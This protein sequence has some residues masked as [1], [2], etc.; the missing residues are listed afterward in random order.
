MKPGKYRSIPKFRL[1][2]LQAWMV[3]GTSGFYIKGSL[4]RFLRGENASPMTHQDL[5]DVIEK[6]EN[7]LGIPADEGIVYILELGHTFLTIKPPPLYLAEWKVLRR[8][9]RDEF[10]SGTSVI[11]RNKTWSMSGYDK[12]LELKEKKIANPYSTKYALRLELRLKKSLAVRFGRKIGLRT[13][14]DKSVWMKCIDLF[15]DTYF[16]IKKAPRI[17]GLGTVG[18]TPRELQRNLAIV[19]ERAVSLDALLAQI[20]AEGCNGSITNQNVRRMKAALLAQENKSGKIILAD[21]L[22]PEIDQMVSNLGSIL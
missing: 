8:T 15:T 10:D 11:F 13:L 1:G 4:G 18:T 2:S 21:A 20:T 3:E 14:L 16:R 6:L 17:N 19:G 5:N 7:E 9:S 12:G 22:Y